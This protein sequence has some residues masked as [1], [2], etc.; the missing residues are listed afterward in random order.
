MKSSDSIGLSRGRG[1]SHPICGRTRRF[2]TIL[3][4]LALI[5]LCGCGR[6]GDDESEQGESGGRQLVRFSATVNGLTVLADMFTAAGD[7]V[8]FRKSFRRCCKRHVT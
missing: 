2:P 8:S 3:I 4:A 5:A 1:M 6:G 7:T